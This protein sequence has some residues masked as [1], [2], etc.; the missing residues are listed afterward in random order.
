MPENKFPLVSVVMPVFNHPAHRLRR[1]IQSI[2]DQT[3]PCFE[4]IVADGTLTDDNLKTVEK[5]ND[6]R[7]IHCRAKGYI[8]CLNLGIEKASGVYIARMDSDDISLPQRLEEQVRF[9]EQN[10]QVDL[11]SCQAELFGDIKPCVTKHPADIDFIT[12]VKQGG[13][14]HPAIMFR[15]RLKVQYEHIKPC[16]DCL[17][18]R[19]LL[20]NGCVIKNL[21][22]VLFKNRVN[23]TSI[24]DRHPK[25][26]TL[27]L[28][29]INLEAFNGFSR[30]KGALGFSA[31]E[32]RRFSVSDFSDF[33]SF[34][35]EIEKS[36]GVYGIKALRMFRPYLD[37]MI[38]HCE[39]KRAVW[40]KLL[41]TPLFYKACSPVSKLVRQIFS[42][43]NKRFPDGRKIKVATVLG[44]EI[45]LKKR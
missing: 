29:K 21:D 27:Y 26:M 8:D 45:P 43:H 10:P 14:L 3:Y 24:M 31:L 32:K 44:R 23:R 19:R 2:L 15:R 16:E 36:D 38:S 4:L 7:I 9:L 39:N 33:F 1:A 22:K 5:F 13:I 28:A 11:C 12:Y 30:L 17:L 37:Y 41:T 35:A 20:L 25:L 42:I 6:P 40:F 18:F 34:V